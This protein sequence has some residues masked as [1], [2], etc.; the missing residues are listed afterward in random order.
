[1][2]LNIIF[3]LIRDHHTEQIWNGSPHHR[4]HAACWLILLLRL[5]ES[6]CHDVSRHVTKQNQQR[7]PLTLKNKKIKN[8]VGTVAGSFPLFWH[9][10]RYWFSD[11]ATAL[12]LQG[13]NISINNLISIPN[14]WLYKFKCGLQSHD[15]FQT[16]VEDTAPQCGYATRDQIIYSS[17]SAALDV[18]MGGSGEEGQLLLWL[19][20]EEA[21]THFL[22]SM[23]PVL[24]L[25]CPP[26]VLPG[27]HHL[28]PNLNLLRTPHHSK[29]Q[30]ALWKR[31]GKV[32]QK[33]QD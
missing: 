7:C 14:H 3:Y 2:S 19:R 10:T 15:I 24:T 4:C 1:M 28:V 9:W 29:W 11:D 13:K 12:R 16:Y 27:P 6:M 22:C 33:C 31:R 30:M 17:I 5:A 23:W 26:G 20:R 32:S 18:N 25:H 8:P 21:C